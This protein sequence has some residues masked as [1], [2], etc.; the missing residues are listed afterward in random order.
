MQVSDLDHATL[1]SAT[2]A[3]TSNVRPFEDKLIFNNLGNMG[4]ITASYDASQGVLNM[5]S[6]GATATTAEWQA[7]LRAVMYTNT[8]DTPDTID[9]RVSFTVNDGIT[10]SATFT[11]TLKVHAVND[12]PLLYNLPTVVLPQNM[13]TLFSSLLISDPDSSTGTLSIRLANPK[14]GVLLEPGLTGSHYD[15]NTGIFTMSGSF[16]SLEAVARKLSFVPAKGHFLTGSNED[17]QV[18]LRIT[19]SSNDSTVYT[20]THIMA[21]PSVEQTDVQLTGINTTEITALA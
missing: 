7:A 18:E 9:R 6:A 8:S 20:S 15:A 4:N 10:N 13:K 17:M 11:E 19:D 1:A 14:A 21:Q 2:V 3:I 5:S 12:T 16:S